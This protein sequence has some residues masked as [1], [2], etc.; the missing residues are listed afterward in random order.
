MTF[1]SG[2][3]VAPPPTRSLTH[4]RNAIIKIVQAGNGFYFILKKHLN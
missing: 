1:S 4:S 2:L 3:L